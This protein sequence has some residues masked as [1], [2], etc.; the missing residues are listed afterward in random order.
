MSDKVEQCFRDKPIEI[1][2][3]ICNCSLCTHTENMLAYA[4]WM[5]KAFQDCME[6]QQDICCSE[7]DNYYE[8][9]G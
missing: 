7:I 8:L 3:T 2:S 6:K 5:D 1:Q 9:I 4:R